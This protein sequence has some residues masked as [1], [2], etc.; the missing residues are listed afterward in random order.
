MLSRLTFLTLALFWLTMTYL[1]WRSEYVGQ[2][3]SGSNVPVDLV[4]RKI[5][6]APDNS[7]L[8]IRHNKQKVG[9]CRLASSIGQELAMGKFLNDSLPPDANSTIITGYR[10]NLEGNVA[11]SETP[12]RMKFDF[13]INLDTNEV[14]R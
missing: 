7:G 4:W 5:L 8:E 1:L 13:E 12:G 11:L 9:Y 6:T 3:K 10:L 14:W 2:K